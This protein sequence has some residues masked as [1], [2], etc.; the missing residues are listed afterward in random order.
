MNKFVTDPARTSYRKPKPPKGKEKKPNLKQNNPLS[1]VRN[2]DGPIDS[3]QPKLVLVPYSLSSLL[4]SSLSLSLFLVL[5]LP[6]L[7]EGEGDSIE[8]YFGIEAAL[9]LRA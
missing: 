1:K 3:C 8:S 4:F 6:S 9:L 5:G 7:L 2:T